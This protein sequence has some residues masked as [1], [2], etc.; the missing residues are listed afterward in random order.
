MTALHRDGYENIY[1]QILG[2]KHFVL[3]PPVEVACVA[4]AMLEPATY[5]YEPEEE[6]KRKGEGEGEGLRDQ[7]GASRRLHIH[8]DDREG[9][10]PF[11]TWD[12]DRPSDRAT[13]FSYLSRPIRLTLAPGD[14]LYLPALWSVPWS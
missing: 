1:C 4:E 13:R 14:M 8:R 3:L 10:I 7:G 12:P 11:P 5:E 9:K 2:R 6:R